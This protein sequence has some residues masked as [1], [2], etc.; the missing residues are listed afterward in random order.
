MM[1]EV[2]SEHAAALNATASRTLIHT[3]DV[4][5]KIKATSVKT[6]CGASRRSASTRKRTRTRRPT[7]AFAMPA[8]PCTAW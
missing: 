7:N 1:Q 4:E 5:Y 3:R 6:A 2:G 8:S